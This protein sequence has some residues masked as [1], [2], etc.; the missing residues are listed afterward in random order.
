MAKT[1]TA[2]NSETSITGRTTSSFT[3]L[4]KFLDDVRT[5][6]R[7]VNT[8]SFKD[9]KATTLVVVITVFLFAAYFYGIDKIIGFFV[10]NILKWAKSA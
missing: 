8:P 2:A 4:K 5:E 9:V 1:A 3:R 7:M 6:M 10:D